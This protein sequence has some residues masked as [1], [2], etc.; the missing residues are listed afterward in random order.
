M[1]WMIKTNNNQDDKMKFNYAKL[2]LTAFYALLSFTLHAETQPKFSLIPTTKTTWTIPANGSAT[3]QYRVTNQLATTK[4]FNH[5]SFLSTQQETNGA[6]L[7]P[8][9]VYL[10]ASRIL[11]IDLIDLGESIN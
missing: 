11:F 2:V 4:T 1:G 5:R 10:S 9:S 3:L 8:K 7:L 6:G